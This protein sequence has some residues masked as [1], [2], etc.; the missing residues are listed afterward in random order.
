MDRGWKRIRLELAGLDKQRVK[1]G[2]QAGDTAPDGTSLAEIGA[3][4]EY[5]TS[6]IPARPFLRAAYEQ[7]QRQLQQFKA[8]LI[9][10]IYERKIDTGKG[11]AILGEKHQQ[12]VQAKIGDGPWVE[13]APSTIAQK[14]SSKPL[15]DTGRLRQSIRYLVTRR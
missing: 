12:Q 10:L 13:N 2:L 5:G 7:Y 1:V 14:G 8:R 9:N 3:F 11:L 6:T 4:N 15:I